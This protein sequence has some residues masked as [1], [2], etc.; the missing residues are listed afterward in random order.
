[1]AT[2]DYLVFQQD[3]HSQDWSSAGAVTATSADAAVRAVALTD[4][5]GVYAAVPARSW[6][7]RTV[8]VEQRASFA[9]DAT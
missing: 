9:K 2:T 8:K 3:E 7:P 6:Q 5:P 4:G 1:M